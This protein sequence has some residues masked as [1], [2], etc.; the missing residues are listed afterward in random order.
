MGG[1]KSFS[2]S[3]TYCATGSPP[4]GRGKVCALG[5]CCLAHGITPAWAGKSLTGSETAAYCRDHP[6]MGGEKAPQ[7]QRLNLI[8]GSPPHGRGKG[9]GAFDCCFLERITPAWAGKRSDTRKPE[10]MHKDHPRMGGEKPSLP[11]VVLTEIGSPPRRRGKE[12]LGGG[13]Y[14]VNRITPAQAGKRP[15]I[16][17]VEV[18]H[19]D[20]PRAGGEKSSGLNELSCI[21]GS[22]PRRRG[23]AFHGIFEGL[24]GGITPAQAGKR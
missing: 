3:S 11:V 10:A 20:H 17:S 8:L 6:R 18:V 5:S 23:K 16:V 12:Y 24:V 4:R 19:E 22:P 14:H 1:E 15:L 9:Q 21:L 13:R 7:G 2:I